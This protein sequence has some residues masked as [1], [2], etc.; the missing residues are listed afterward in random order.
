[1]EY[2]DTQQGEL[3]EYFDVIKTRKWTILLVFLLV[4]G[5]ALFISYRKTPQYV[6]GTRLLV[7][8]V[9]QGE[10]GFINAPDLGT[11]AEVLQSVEVARLVRQD[12]ELKMSPDRLLGGLSAT[13]VEETSVLEI[14]Y[15]SN[16][17]QFAADAANSFATS[18]VRFQQEGAQEALL[19]AANEIKEEITKTENQ[20]EVITE[21]LEVAEKQ[22]AETVPLL[23]QR[24]S[25]KAAALELL[26]QRLA[27]TL[28][29][30]AVALGGGR[31]LQPAT[32]PGAPSS[33]SHRTDG[34]LGGMLGLLLGFGAGFA[35]DRL[36]S[37]FRS[38]SDAERTLA[39]PVLATVPRF[40]IK[41]RSAVPVLSVDPTSAAS[42]AYRTLRTNLQFLASQ[43]DAKSI[44]ITSPTSSEGKTVTA[45]NLAA[46]FAQA[47]QRVVLVSGDLRRPSVELY[48]EVNAQQ[49]I[50]LAGWLQG[51]V[52]EVDKILVDTHV[53]NLT[54]VPSGPI[55]SHPAELLTS[56]RLNRLIERLGETHDIVLFDSVPALALADAA[57]TASRADAAV[58]V[59]DVTATPRPSAIHAKAELERVGSQVLGTVLN[60]Y[61]T[62]T[63]PYYYSEYSPKAPA[64]VGG[65]GAGN[66][67]GEVRQKKSLFRRSR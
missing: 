45:V 51:D 40:K 65:N 25:D 6:A 31:L 4:L 10:T 7:K 13:P 33:P 20:L 61:E 1:M 56:P 66:G 32:P 57:I 30:S 34:I 58:L 38:R 39:L 55:P 53:P 36:D 5:V 15:I 12:L 59:I 11:E 14:T 9:P 16:D 50:G 26:E 41:G 27:A 49:H 64:N 63:S 54:L 22:G 44:V 67:A 43:R 42:E 21:K 47:G 23:Q 28:P 52:S 60:H 3:R 24:Q 62:G 2:P 8:G 19:T 17:P 37:R 46:A 18:Y 48:F 35:K 29:D